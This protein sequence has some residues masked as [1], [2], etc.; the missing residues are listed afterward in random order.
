M[1][2]SFPN[3]Q[4]TE[5]NKMPHHYILPSVI[6][7]NYN[8][9][10]MTNYKSCSTFLK[11]HQFQSQPSGYWRYRLLNYNTQILRV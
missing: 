2:P 1:V 4:K 8:W 11:I 6:F 5:K 9:L 7:D 10:V 3:G